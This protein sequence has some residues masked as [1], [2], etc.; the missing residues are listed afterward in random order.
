MAEDP[1][2]LGLTEEAAAT[3]AQASR[4]LQYVNEDNIYLLTDGAWR[5]YKNS[6]TAIMQRIQ[7]AFGNPD[8]FKVYVWYNGASAQ[9]VQITSV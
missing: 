2:P 3:V 4:V 6:S 1:K 8:R 7:D 9:T 5:N